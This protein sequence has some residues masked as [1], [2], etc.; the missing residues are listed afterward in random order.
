MCF[1]IVTSA[2]SLLAEL[3]DKLLLFMN[4]RNVDLQSVVVPETVSTSSTRVPHP[5]VHSLMP[6]HSPLWWKWSPTESA[7][8]WRC[9][10]VDRL[11]K[12]FMWQHALFTPNQPAMLWNATVSIQPQWFRDSLTDWSISLDETFRQHTYKIIAKTSEGRSAENQYLFGTLVETSI[13]GNPCMKKC[14]V[15]GSFWKDQDMT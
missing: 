2:E 8:V 4:S 12:L 13:G 6:E 5:H 15:K 11:Q 3:T 9:S 10:A 7:W 14:G 1:K